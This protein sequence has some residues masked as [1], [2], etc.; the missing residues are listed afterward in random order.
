MVPPGQQEA[1]ERALLENYY[2]VQAA[3]TAFDY[4]DDAF[5]QS[6]EENAETS[7]ERKYA[8]WLRRNAREEI[9]EVTEMQASLQA[10]VK[11]WLIEQA[12]GA[13]EAVPP[14]C[15]GIH[16]GLLQVAEQTASLG[17]HVEAEKMGQAAVDGCTKARDAAVA[18]GKAAS[19]GVGAFLSCGMMT[20]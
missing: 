9:A 5:L 11:S 13:L 14:E 10:I 7:T 18:W 12:K 20:V 17:D 19:S 16:L 2:E 3:V 15:K 8:E 4:T 1:F 6:L